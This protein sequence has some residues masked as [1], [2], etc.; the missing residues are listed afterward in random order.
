LSMEM[1]CLSTPEKAVK[2]NKTGGD[3]T[4]LHRTTVARACRARLPLTV[5]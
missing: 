1:R 5:C 4:A 3:R 2:K